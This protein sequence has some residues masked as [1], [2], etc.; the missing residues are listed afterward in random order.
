MG[1]YLSHS[2]ISLIPSK[3]K[4]IFIIVVSFTL[5]HLRIFSFSIS[6]CTGYFNQQEDLPRG[7]FGVV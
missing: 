1:G 6:S 4:R 3:L 7:P 2:L 5:Y